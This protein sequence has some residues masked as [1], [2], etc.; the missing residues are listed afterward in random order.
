MLKNRISNKKLLVIKPEDKALM[1]KIMP[2]NIRGRI[3][4]QVY[5]M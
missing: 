5:T 3:Q 1:L 2:E 4:P